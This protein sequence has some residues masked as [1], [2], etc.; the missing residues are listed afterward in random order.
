MNCL[1]CL[2][3]LSALNLMTRDIRFSHE[4]GFICLWIVYLQKILCEF[5]ICGL[6]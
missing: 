5:S 6:L 4:E 1:S 2:V 3:V